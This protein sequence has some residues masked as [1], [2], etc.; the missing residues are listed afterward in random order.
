MVLFRH[1]AKGGNVTY[2]GITLFT[3]VYSFKKGTTWRRTGV[4]LDCPVSGPA[5]EAYGQRVQECQG[6]RKYL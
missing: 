6:M 3:V 1:I 2:Y 5:I 4:V